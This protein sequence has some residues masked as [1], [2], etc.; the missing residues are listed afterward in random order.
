MLEAVPQRPHR[1]GYKEH[2]LVVP[3]RL[4]KKKK[5][6]RPLFLSSVFLCMKQAVRR[7]VNSVNE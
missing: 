5:L 3:G 7:N 4:Q 6:K 2:Q 1:I